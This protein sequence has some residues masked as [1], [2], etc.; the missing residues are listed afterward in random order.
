MLDRG[1]DYWKL[2]VVWMIGSVYL[3]TILYYTGYLLLDYIQGV[4]PILRS[5]SSFIIRCV[6]VRI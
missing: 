5:I 4:V 1:L 3:Y 6:Y 2:R